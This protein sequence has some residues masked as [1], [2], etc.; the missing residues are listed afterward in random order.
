MHAPLLGSTLNLSIIKL[1]LLHE[2]QINY[3]IITAQ[4]ILSSE[5]SLLT[6]LQY[7]VGRLKGNGEYSG[8]L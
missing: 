1:L 3:I 2:L 5:L 4:I 7:V 6:F 8:K